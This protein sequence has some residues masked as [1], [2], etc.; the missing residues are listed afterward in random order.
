MPNPHIHPRYE[1]L[2]HKDYP[3]PGDEVAFILDSEISSSNPL[4]VTVRNIYGDSQAL[5]SVSAEH[6]ATCFIQSDVHPLLKD[7]GYKGNSDKIDASVHCAQMA[8]YL[9]RDYEAFTLALT[10]L[11]ELCCEQESTNGIS[12]DG[13]ELVSVLAAYRGDYE[14]MVRDFTEACDAGRASEVCS[15][16]RTRLNEYSTG[17]G[18]SPTPFARSQGVKI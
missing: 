17:N 5:R 2:V 10:N 1:I 3:Q 18:E 16:L 12:F 15:L 14:T 8:A 11:D 7:Y 9:V 4:P 6:L 13:A